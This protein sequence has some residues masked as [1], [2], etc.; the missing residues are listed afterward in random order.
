MPT[1]HLPEPFRRVGVPLRGGSFPDS[2][3]GTSLPAEPSGGG[4]LPR[5][6]IRP[7]HTNHQRTQIMKTPEPITATVTLAEIEE[8]TRRYAAA[9]EVL[10]G[11]LGTLREQIRTLERRHRPRLKNAVDLTGRARAELAAAVEAA[12]ELFAQPRTRVFHGVK[13]GL[14][15]GRGGLVFDDADAVVA[16]IHAEFGDA[17]SAFLRVKEA[18][19]L[20]MLA[21]L[22]PEELDRLGCRWEDA[23]D[24]VVIRPTDSDTEKSARALL[25]SY[26]AEE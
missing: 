10:A 22:T 17:A 8:H 2:A 23:S 25:E 19:D 18:P 14:Q 3:G 5:P 21:Q 15:R 6:P 11:V 13:V 1:S 12:P 4:N 16:R 24:T 9:Q 7:N 20:K 26:E